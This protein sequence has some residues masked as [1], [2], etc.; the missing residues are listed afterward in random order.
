VTI[1]WVGYET[2]VEAVRRAEWHVGGIARTLVDAAEDDSGQPAPSQAFLAR[3]AGALDEF[4]AALEHFGVDDEQE[5]A[6]VRDHLDNALESLRSL[7]REVREAR[8]QNPDA[9]PA[10]GSLILLAQRMAR[11]LLAHRE[12]AVV[13][14]DSGPIRTPRWR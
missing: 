13:P 6:L 8:L 10:Y 3:Y 5:R 4:T 7:S 1:D 9:W 2:L 14:T 11:E 12:Q